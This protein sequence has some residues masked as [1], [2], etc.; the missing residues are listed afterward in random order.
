LCRSAAIVLIIVFE[1]AERRLFGFVGR[2]LGLFRLERRRLLRRF[3]QQHAQRRL[4]EL[5][6]LPVIGWL[7]RR[8]WFIRWCFLFI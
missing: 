2:F 5:G 1:H 7:E 4:E 6:W 3:L 8:R